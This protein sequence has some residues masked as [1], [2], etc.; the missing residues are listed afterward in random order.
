MPKK[1]IDPTECIK[2][3]ICGIPCLLEVTYYKK[4][5]HWKGSPLMCPSDLDYYG[6]T[7]VEFEIRDSKGYLAPWLEKKVTEEI[8]KDLEVAILENYQEHN[9][10]ESEDE[11]SI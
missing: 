3:S 4:I 9:I 1:G 2:A 6:Y 7:E 10:E 5:P 11:H 8:R